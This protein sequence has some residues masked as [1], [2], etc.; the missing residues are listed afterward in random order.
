MNNSVTKSIISEIAGTATEVGFEALA[1]LAGF[2]MANLALPFAKGLVLGL[3]ENCYNDCAQKTLSIRETK[4]LNRISTIALQTFRELA[5]KDGVVAWEM[6]IDPAYIDYSYEVA[7]HATMEAIRQSEL[8]KVDILGRYYGKQF[9][10]GA[11]DWQDM[12]QIITMTSTL[13]LRQIVLIRLISIDFKGIDTNLFVS[14]PSACVEINQLLDYG[15]WQ[16]EGASFGTNDSWAIQ[17]RSIIPTVYSDDV[18]KALMLDHLSE[19]DV[20]RTVDSLRLTMEGT[21]QRELTE[22]DFDKRTTFKVVGERLILPD[23]KSFGKE[24][25]DEDMFLYDLARGK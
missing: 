20:K 16:T 2:P 4:K 10:E 6:N 1:S 15:I 23:G 24:N 7:E 21:P 13:S 3:L 25:D 5:E 14:N 11:V 22:E 17:L 18:S 8:A 19:E 12:H 9:Y